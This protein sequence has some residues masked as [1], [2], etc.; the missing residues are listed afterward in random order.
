MSEALSPHTYRYTI[1]NAKHLQSS[2][3]PIH[4]KCDETPAGS[5]MNRS[6]AT[7]DLS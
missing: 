7:F 4:K 1:P 5:I 3:N 2:V 6:Q